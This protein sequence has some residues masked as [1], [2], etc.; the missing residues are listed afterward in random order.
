[1]LRYRL[2][3]FVLEKEFAIMKRANIVRALKDKMYRRGLSEKQVKEVGR[4]PA[5]MA[6]LDASLLG[7]VGGGATINSCGTSLNPSLCTN[8]TL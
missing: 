7:A 8:C 1:M 2:D 4:D 6:E 3:R 5:G